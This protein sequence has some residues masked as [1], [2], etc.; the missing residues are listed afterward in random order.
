LQSEK[1]IDSPVIAFLKK[2][3]VIKATSYQPV[4]ESSNF[5]LPGMLK[6][7]RVLPDECEED[8]FNFKNPQTLK[9]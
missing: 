7:I 1:Q 6:P 8:L 9:P 5:V 4:N 2:E 3:V